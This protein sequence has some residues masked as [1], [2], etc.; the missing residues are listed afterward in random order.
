MKL[1]Q[2]V[3][4]FFV[5]MV[6]SIGLAGAQNQSDSW[7]LTESGLV[8]KIYQDATILSKLTAQEE[9]SS[10]LSL[11]E[12]SL[13]QP[14]WK[15]EVYYQ[16]SNEK[17][18]ASF[19]PTFGPTHG[20]QTG[21]YKRFTRGVEV[22]ANLFSDLSSTKDN[23]IDHATR[24]GINL[25]AK[26]D[27][28]K[29]LFG[30][31]DQAKLQSKELALKKMALENQIAI[32]SFELEMRK[33]YWSLVAI[34]EKITI[35]KK[36]LESASL[37]YKDSVSRKNK[38]IADATETDRYKAQVASRQATL[39]ALE[40]QRDLA[41]QEIKKFIP[42]LSSLHIE[43]GE[44]DREKAVN[45]VLACVMT[46]KQFDQAPWDH[47]LLDEILALIE[48]DYEQQKII[49]E[50][51]DGIDVALQSEVQMS[52]VDRGYQDS[53]S[54]FSSNPK[55]GF[56]VGLMVDVPLGKSK[57]KVKSAK[58]RAQYESFLTNKKETQ[59]SVNA[60]QSQLLAMIDTLFAST[61]NYKE[62]SATLSSNVQRIQKKYAQARVDVRDL[63]L[64]QDAFF[65]NAL[66]EVDSHLAVMEVLLDYF[67]IFTLDP[68]PINQVYTAYYTPSER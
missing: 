47:T 61:K 17:A 65:Q 67:K 33:V 3:L 55:A 20:F 5:T 30:R 15:N 56:Q 9:L 36:L 6:L 19:I 16:N 1:F 25:Q 50:S 22:Q 40:Y 7:T 26:I 43:M 8:E 13:Y 48:K 62:N 60:H 24:T 44:Y 59:A 2:Y 46:I 37:Q 14:I 29:N 27:L 35:S 68:C 54:D 4:S 66:N 49:D 52:G 23:V 18:L 64:E 58:L 51:F 28:W 53:F 38:F 31:L 63:V 12:R 45:T 10:S 42:T 11:E 32:R 34:E 21:L 57:N 41:R 39:Y